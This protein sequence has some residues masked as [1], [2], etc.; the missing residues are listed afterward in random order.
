[1]TLDLKAVIDGL[2]LEGAV[3]VGWSYGPLV[4]LDYIRHYGE[5]KLGGLD[6]KLVHRIAG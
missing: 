3:P 5:R 1:M 2:D 6:A 4:I